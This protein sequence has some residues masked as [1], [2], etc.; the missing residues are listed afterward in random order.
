MFFLIPIHKTLPRLEC[1]RSVTVEKKNWIWPSATNTKKN[2]P[3][4]PAQAR[5]KPRPSSTTEGWSPEPGFSMSFIKKWNRNSRDG[6]CFL[7]PNTHNPS[8]AAAA[9]CYQ[10]RTMLEHSIM[11]CVICVDV[12][13]KLH[14][15]FLYENTINAS[16][17]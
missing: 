10:R 4:T 16:L 17:S 7:N 6:V 11:I 15:T 1:A 2:R 3:R 12:S 13:Y 5:Q 14:S 8:G 9:G